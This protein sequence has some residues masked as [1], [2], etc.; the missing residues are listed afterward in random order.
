[1]AANGLDVG[2]MS[3]DEVM[4]AYA[5]AR[6]SEMGADTDLEPSQVIDEA[7]EPVDDLDVVRGLPPVTG[8]DEPEE[9][10]GTLVPEPAAGFDS[11]VAKKVVKE[12]SRRQS[13]EERNLELEKELAARGV[14]LENAQSQLRQWQQTLENAK[15]QREQQDA[16]EQASQAAAARAAEDPE[17]DPNVDWA[18]HVEWKNRKL[19]EKLARLEGALE[20]RTQQ[21]TGALNI[22]QAKA[23]INQRIVEMG[24]AEDAFAQQ[25]GFEDYHDAYDHLEKVHRTELQA[26]YG[27]A[28][29]PQTGNPYWH[30]ELESRRARLLASCFN[31][32]P[33]TG[34]PDARFGWN[35]QR[36]LPTIVYQLARATGYGGRAAAVEEAPARGMA[37]AITGNGRQG[38]PAD[39]GRR[40]IPRTGVRASDRAAAVARNTAAAAGRDVGHGAAASSTNMDAEALAKMSKEDF[41][42]F[43]D[44]QQKVLKAVMHG[45]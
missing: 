19:E 29:N 16:A 27:E 12:R 32:N 7:T 22:E 8:V 38:M 31:V 42:A 30:D 35:P 20:G 45:A 36:H 5:N 6:D 40:A 37:A 13:L 10:D 17:P 34:R 1:M 23:A 28:V 24:A 21:F 2:K 41:E 18:E 33:Q 4:N 25:K 44:S 43:Y 11:S 26:L 14:H 3:A 15:R 39:A 9:D